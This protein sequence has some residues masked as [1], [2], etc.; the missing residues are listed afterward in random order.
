M[1][2][3]EGLSHVTGMAELG[4]G[5]S[6]H[7]HIHFVLSGEQNQNQIAGGFVK[8]SLKNSELCTSKVRRQG[9]IK[10]T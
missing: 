5:W 2:S 3:E 9:T 1:W 8:N 10:V 6:Q 4:E 7:T